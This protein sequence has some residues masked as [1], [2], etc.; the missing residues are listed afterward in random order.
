[1]LFDFQ[2]TQCN[3]KFEV[4]IDSKERDQ[5]IPCEVCTEDAKR[6]ISPVRVRLE[7]ITGHFPTAYNQWERKRKQKM[8]QEKKAVKEHGSDA[9]WDCQKQY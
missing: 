6:V 9:Q 1:M 5:P 7:G 8:E 3:H 4:L 2:C